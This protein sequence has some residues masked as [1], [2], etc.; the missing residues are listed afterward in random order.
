[1]AGMIRALKPPK[2]AGEIVAMTEFQ[3]QIIVA[4]QFRVYR[5]INNLFEPIIFAEPRD[6]VGKGAKK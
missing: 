4:C 5:L 6:G 3:G 2:E 1:M